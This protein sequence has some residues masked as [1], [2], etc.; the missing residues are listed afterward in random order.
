MNN[1]IVR[2]WKDEFYRQ[3]LSDEERAQMP[4]NPVG[5]LELTDVELGS[6][7]AAGGHNEPEHH[8]SY[9]FC[10]HNSECAHPRY[11]YDRHA[12]HHINS[13]GR[14]WDGCHTYKDE[15]HR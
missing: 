5:E 6:V 13:Y 1:N 11:S 12:C 10:T 3:S 14:D 8:F 9:S 2:A 7:F 4:V 15:E